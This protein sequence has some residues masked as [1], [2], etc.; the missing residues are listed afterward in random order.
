MP[1]LLFCLLVILLAACNRQPL[2]SPETTEDFDDVGESQTFFLSPDQAGLSAAAVSET[3]RLVV[4]L[5]VPLDPTNSTLRYGSMRVAWGGDSATISGTTSLRLYSR[6]TPSQ[7]A[8]ANDLDIVANST[9][10]TTGTV[11]RSFGTMCLEAN[12]SVTVSTGQTFDTNG[13]PLEFCTQTKREVASSTLKLENPVTDPSEL[14]FGE[15]QYVN[16]N[17]VNSGRQNARIGSL[18]IGLQLPPG[19]SFVKDD[20]S[21]FECSA[22]GQLVECRNILVM[23]VGVRGLPIQVV[24]NERCLPEDCEALAVAGQ[25]MYTDTIEASISGVANSTLSLGIHAD[26]ALMLAANDLTGTTNEN[27]NFSVNVSNRGQT[28]RS[29]VVVTLTNGALEFVSESS[30]QFNCSQNTTSGLGTITCQAAAA[31][32]VGSFS[33]PLVVKSAE[34]IA[35]G[36]ANGFDKIRLRAAAD[37]QWN[38]AAVNLTTQACVTFP[39]NK[40]EAAV[41]EALTMPTGRICASDMQNLFELDGFFRGITNLTGLEYATNLASLDLGENNITDISP[42]ANLTSLSNLDLSLNTGLT[43]IS[44]LAGLSNLLS[45][46]LYGTNPASISVLSGLTSLQKLNLSFTGISDISALAPLVDL[47]DL[48]LSDNALTSLSALASLTKLITLNLSFTGPNDLSPLSGLPL[49]ETLNLSDSNLTNVSPLGAITSLKDLNLT[50]NL[51]TDIAALSSLVNVISLDLGYN[52]IADL[53]GL[54]TLVNLENLVLEQNLFSDI[55]PLVDNLG[56]GTGDFISLINN[57]N[58]IRP[59]ASLDIQILKDRGADV[60]DD[61][62]D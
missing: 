44:L 36:N 23:P 34:V 17:V 54:E 13:I 22:L 8:E 4:T 29:N 20:S 9:S 11:S 10:F 26:A 52:S 59:K 42:L 19:L 16:I 56:L 40:L 62:I 32:P 33:I 51:I 28:A 50:Q 18:L 7:F 31:L 37:V 6:K 14:V 41:R 45:L 55:Q 27:M 25:R 58:L 35:L 5:A 30:S 15:N 60:I 48:D 39:D 43:D 21:L 12:L 24:A 2:P 46:N 61:V 53:T 47:T 1:R 49:L 57:P 3:G 38:V